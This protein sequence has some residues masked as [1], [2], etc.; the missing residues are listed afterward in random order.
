MPEDFPG[1]PR[2]EKGALIVYDTNEV[3][4]QPSATIY[5]QY[6]PETM[7]RTLAARTPP[8]SGRDVGGAREEVLRVQ[9]PPVETINL[10]I[11]L[12]ATEQLGESNP[13]QTVVE[14][15]LHPALA[16]L[17][18]LLY[19]PSA[20]ADEIAQQAERGAVQVAE[21]DLPL[22][23]LSWGRSRVVPVQLTSF[24][25]T[26]EAF[27]EKLNPILARVELGMRV[28]TYVEFPNRSVARDAFIAYQ[29]EKENLAGLG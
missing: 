27:D 16:T 5:F 14:N 25:V 21:A 26:E 29:Q 20:R 4:T 28:L 18:L 19:P 12:D 2:L 22:T 10:T 8:S 17:E 9:G 13:N 15:G 3:E 24:S 1:R 7:R 23:L 11:E 6:N